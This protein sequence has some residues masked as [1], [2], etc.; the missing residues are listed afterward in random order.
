MIGSLV[1]RSGLLSL[2]KLLL[3]LGHPSFQDLDTLPQPRQLTVQHRRVV[4]FSF[5]HRSPLVI[6]VRCYELISTAR[7]LDSLGAVRAI[8][9]L[10]RPSL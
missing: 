1:R 2:A 9:T 8:R 10:K 5:R 3:E 4:F 6:E 7:A